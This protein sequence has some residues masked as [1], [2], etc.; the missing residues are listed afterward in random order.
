MGILT[1]FF[2]R[3]PPSLE[4]AQTIFEKLERMA[5]LDDPMSALQ[6]MS[7]AEFRNLPSAIIGPGGSLHDRLLAILSKIK[8]HVEKKAGSPS[9]QKVTRNWDNLP[10]V[11]ALTMDRSVDILSAV[12]SSGKDLVC[13]IPTGEWTSGNKML[14]DK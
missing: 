11:V 13:L 1:S 7:S 5:E 3:K 12:A 9:T 8:P 2:G 6:F 14:T 4:E 10:S